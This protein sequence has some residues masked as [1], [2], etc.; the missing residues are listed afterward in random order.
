MELRPR[1][2]A[3]N[4]GA[5]LAGRGG[6]ASGGAMPDGGRRDLRATLRAGAQQAAQVLARVEV[7]A[8][9][10]A[11]IVLSLLPFPWV[12]HLNWPF[13]LLFGVELCVR[14]VAFLGPVD[15]QT[16]AAPGRHRL[17]HGVLL[18]LDLIALLSFLPWSMGGPRW[19][20]LVRLSRLLLLIS[21]WAPVVRDL[22][23]VLGQRERSRQVLLMGFS[24]LLFAFVGAVL[25]E[26]LTPEGVDFDGDGRQDHHD[27]RFS[28]RLW[29][30]FRQ[31]QDPG[32]MLQAPS[33]VVAVAVSFALTVSGLFLV[34]FLIG[35]GTDVVRAMLDLSRS[36]PP[37]LRG[38][39]VVVHVTPSTP[40][41]MTELVRH[42]Q[43]LF[44]TARAALLGRADDR[45][46]FLD[47]PGLRHIVYRS[48][49]EGKLQ[50]LTRVDAHR[51]RRIVVQADARDA[52]ADAETA[53]FVLGLREKNRQALVVAEVLDPRNVSVTRVAGGPRT[54]IVPTEKL[55]GLL[56]AATATQPRLEALLRELLSSA[57]HEVYSFLYDSED[58][59][60]PRTVL[61]LG[62]DA[63][64]ARL[65]DAGL[66]P[67]PEGH[68]AVVLGVLRP[69]TAKTPYRPLLGAALDGRPAAEPVYG[70]LA[71]AVS[72]GAMRRM[73]LRFARHG[74]PPPERPPVTAPPL[75]A[76]D[77]PPPRTVLICG[78]RP[79]GVHLLESLMLGAPDVDVQLLV[80]TRAE[81]DATLAMLHDHS[82]HQQ[83][84]LWHEA[85]PLG[86]FETIE[87]D[88]AAHF[89]YRADGAQC[90]AGA[91]RIDIADWTREGTLLAPPGG[92]PLSQVHLAV[93]LG[94][95]HPD[96]DA[97]TAVAVLKIA[98]LVGAGQVT[99]DPRF[100]LL[101]VMVEDALATLVETRFCAAAGAGPSRIDVFATRE[102]AAYF[103]FQSAVVPGFDALYSELLSPWGQS[104]VRLEPLAEAPEAHR[105][106]T[107]AELARSLAREGRTL[108][109]LELPAPDGGVRLCVAP[110]PGDEGDR[111]V[112]AQLAGLWVMG[113]RG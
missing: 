2:G 105:P 103:N 60:T 109:A 21:Y 3:R 37:G 58:Y 27:R 30:A 13:L 31:V 11:A 9:L 24:V 92:R 50:G 15:D 94:T 10:S 75:R 112:P 14:V 48:S 59:D 80:R 43:K 57:G 28:T 18:G 99:F 95:P 73:A 55:I 33:D 71:I 86:R 49:A 100:R 70:L 35:L 65:L 36:R 62:A 63:D 113:P 42:Y 79:A 12:Q 7:R 88:G 64:H 46:A 6:E 85:G 107:F 87:G 83:L 25:L 110:G 68:R 44:T 76:A 84:G 98:D 81:L 4:V 61:R 54:I 91:L 29:W 22:R 74:L 69:P 34:S 53:R 106:W 38:H 52:A 17:F 67:S 93:V 1:P 26:H 82:L 41:L 104:F 39:L 5:P 16:D 102:F 19:L 101:A 32:N 78:F 40:R 45:P 108:L 111:F 51:A 96:T 89:T 77:L 20:R 90:P 23:V 47:A 8:L 97:L 72:F 56:V 66:R